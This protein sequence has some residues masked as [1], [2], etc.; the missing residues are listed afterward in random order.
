MANRIISDDAEI[1]SVRLKESAA[2]ATP[3]SGYGQLYAKTDGKIYFK[4][5]DGLEVDLT[6]TGSASAAASALKGAIVSVGGLNVTGSIIQPIVW[7]A[8]VQDDDNY[9]D[10]GNPTRFVVN[11]TGWYLISCQ[12][13]WD[14]NTTNSRQILMY[15]N[16]IRS[17]W[18]NKFLASTNEPKTAINA[19]HYLISGTNIS[20][21][22]FQ[23]TSTRAIVTGTFSI[24]NYT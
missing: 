17:A 22:A 13:K 2:P 20:V 18:E 6:L 24:I 16:D 14:N 1:N 11:H 15:I 12:T 4:N 3:A 10:A 19:L 21:H 9:W 23:D 8:E 7:S 5:D